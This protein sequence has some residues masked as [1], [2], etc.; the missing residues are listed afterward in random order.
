M[1]QTIDNHSSSIRQAFAEDPDQQRKLLNELEAELCDLLP[2]QVLSSNIARLAT[3]ALGNRVKALSVT[4]SHQHFDQDELVHSGNLRPSWPLSA[5]EE[6]RRSNSDQFS[7][8]LG[9]ILDSEFGHRVVERGPSVDDVTSL[10]SFRRFWGEEKCEIRRFQDGSIIEAVIWDE[11][12][13]EK[14]WVPRGERIVEEILRHILSRHLPGFCGGV[15]GSILSKTSQLEHHFLSGNVTNGRSNFV[16]DASSMFKRIV[17][18]FDQLR[19]I[20]IS[21]LNGIPLVIES[22][23]TTSP[24]LRYS[25]VM[26][27]A[28]HPL[29]TPGGRRTFLEKLFRF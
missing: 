7:V 3:E 1:L 5:S 8:T 16:S 21:D 12:A 25:G 23:V 26:P 14:G 11:E 6:V 20:L 15:T 28:P 29:L 22:V 19:R 17:E 27:I 24:M 13:S 18:Q 4:L 2:F 9:L 10:L